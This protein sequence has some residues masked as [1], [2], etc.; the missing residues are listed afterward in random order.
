MKHPAAKSLMCRQKLRL[1][2]G[3]DALEA[4]KQIGNSRGVSG[5]N[6]SNHSR[7]NKARLPPGAERIVNSICSNQVRRSTRKEC[8]SAMTALN[9]GKIRYVLL[10]CSMNWLKLTLA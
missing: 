9:S 7:S 5:V 2:Y 1:D 10:H 8:V 3:R 4:V 6:A